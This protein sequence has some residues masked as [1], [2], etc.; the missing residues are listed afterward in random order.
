MPTSLKL[1][2]FENLLRSTSIIL[3]LIYYKSFYNI[4]LIRNYLV[5][6]YDQIGSLMGQGASTGV[7]YCLASKAVKK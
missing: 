5:K 4:D 3:D 1:V 2:G 7:K 6:P